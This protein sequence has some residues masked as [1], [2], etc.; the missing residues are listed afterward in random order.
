[1]DPDTL[2]ALFAPYADGSALDREKENPLSKQDFYEDGLSGGENSRA[3][4]DAL[5][6]SFGLPAGMTANAL[7]AA[8][9]LL[10]TYEAYKAAVTALRT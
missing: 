10:C 8:L 1:M 7:L 5:A 2:R 4:R 9:R 3:M 6:A